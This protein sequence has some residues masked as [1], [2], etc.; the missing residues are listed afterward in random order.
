LKKTYILDTN[1][2][3][4]DSNVL[5]KY[6]SN[7]ILIPFKVLEEID[8]H[9][10]RQDAAGYNAR[11]TIKVLD[12]LR[13]KG[14]FK[15]GIRIGKGLG[16][17]CVKS[18]DK[19]TKYPDTLDLSSPDNEILA[20]ALSE[21][22]SAAGRKI[23]LVTRDINMRVKCNSLGILVE[24]YAHS[25]V[26]NK[27]E[28]I[29]SGFNTCLVD[30]QVVDGFYKDLPVCLEKEDG[31]FYPNQYLMLV[32]S[33]NDKKTALCRFIGYGVPL[34]K[35]SEFKNGVWGIRPKNKEQQFA[36]DALLD[37]EIPIVSLT[38][39]AGT[40]KSLMALAAGL[41]QVL[42]KNPPYRRLVVTRPIQ[43]MGKDLGFLPGSKEEKMNPWL[44]PIQDNLKFLLED[45]SA[46]LPAYVDRGIIEVEALTYIRGRSIANAYIICDEFQNTSPL[47]IK[48]M[49]TRVGEGSKIVLTGDI[50]QLDTSYNELTNGL[51]IAVEKFKEQEL[52]GHITLTKGERSKVATLAAKVL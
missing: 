29:Y 51:T 48:T 27:K 33:Q 1:V 30:E 39:T 42:G 36:L 38:G 34:R 47:E 11:C 12:G 35:V 6:G 22:A 18:Y 37:R 50:F 9:K 26:V 24:G 19:G 23:V 45:D 7:D 20:L 28:Q 41:E 16:V 31:R 8:K 43:P 32:S 52:A 14:Q 3:L 44:A 5:Y 15:S 4:A 21:M 40:G 2:Y 49:I 46:T 10:N 17:L 25:S 13:E